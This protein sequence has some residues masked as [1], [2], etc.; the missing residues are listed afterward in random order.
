MS[1]LNVPELNLNP[2]DPQEGIYFNV[3]EKVYRMAQG[4]SQSD[5]KESEYYM[6][7][8]FEAKFGAKK[9]STDAQVTGTLLHALTLQKKELFVVVPDGAPNKPTKTQ[10]NAKKPSEETVAAIAWWKAFEAQHHGKEFVSAKEAFELRTM[11]DAIF[12]NEDAAEMLGRTNQFEVAGFKKHHTGLMLK[13]LADAICID[14]HNYIVVPDIKTTQRGGASY[15]AF[16]KDILW[17]GYHRQAA[18]YIDLFG[19]SFFCF[20]C[21]EKEPPYAV[22][23]YWAD[24]LTVVSR[25]RAENEQDLMRIAECERTGV[26]P[27]YPKGIQTMTLKD[28]RS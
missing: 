24:P 12:A 17:W 22:A 18:F 8:C 25:G 11:R 19:A 6:L 26:W 20:I 5:L 3:P 21:V 1:A 23:C 2:D 14:D 28:Y 13:G 27:G 7:H 16:Q 9:K 4:W 15:D 10:L